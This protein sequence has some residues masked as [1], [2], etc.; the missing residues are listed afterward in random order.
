MLVA[1]VVLQ[2]DAG[3]FAKGLPIG[4]IRWG[5]EVQNGRSSWTA[6]QL[7]NCTIIIEGAWKQDFSKDGKKAFL[8]TSG[9]LAKGSFDVGARR[10]AVANTGVGL[11]FDALPKTGGRSWKLSKIGIEMAGG[12]AY[13]TALVQNGRTHF[14]VAKRSRIAVIARPKLLS[15]PAH[16]PDHK[17]QTYPDSFLIAIQGSAKILPA[18]SAAFERSR[19]KSKRQAGVGNGP[20]RPGTPFGFV[21]AQLQPNAAVGLAGTGTVLDGPVLET[22]EDATVDVQPVAPA[23]VVTV[24][25]ERNMEF[26]MAPGIHTALLC[27]FG[28]HCEPA[29]GGT[30]ALTGGFTFSYSGRTVT[31]TDI[32]AKYVKSSNGSVLPELEATVDGTRM[33]IALAGRPDG[34]DAYRAYL[35]Q[36][37]GLTVYSA[38]LRLV[39]SFTSTGPA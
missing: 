6:R 38:A 31:V 28:Y 12:K 37:L 2:A 29:E 9:G 17:G 4:A 1:F 13:V 35:S 20:I 32:A 30:Y 36:V 3:A 33:T 22:D 23:K 16:V 19:C 26:P 18:L 11:E 8:G 21:T 39:P 7:A 15:G 10:G 5:V 25:R 34:T 14:V 24:K 27:Q